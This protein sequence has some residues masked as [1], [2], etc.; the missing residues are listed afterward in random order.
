MYKTIET[1]HVSPAASQFLRSMV[2]L[3]CC[4]LS[5]LMHSGSCFSYFSLKPIVQFVHIDII[6]LFCLAQRDQHIGMTDVCNCFWTDCFVCG[7]SS[8][9]PCLK[10]SMTIFQGP[11]LG[12]FLQG[13]AL[14]FCFYKIVVCIV[15]SSPLACIYDEF[16][17][18]LYLSAYDSS[19]PASQPSRAATGTEWKGAPP[20]ELIKYPYS[21]PPV[22]SPTPGT[23]STLPAVT[24]QQPLQHHHSTVLPTDY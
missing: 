9:S 11:F 2:I 4:L 5:C 7:T 20:E 22:L 3:I 13:S 24:A 16:P 21:N 19:S 17:P 8:T 10:N 14:N 1:F 12:P 18:C 15:T 6:S 23:F